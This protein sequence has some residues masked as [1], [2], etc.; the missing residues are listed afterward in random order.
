MRSQTPR[1]DSSA[2]PVPSQANG[3]GLQPV[4]KVRESPDGAPQSATDEAARRVQSSSSSE[5]SAAREAPRLRAPL[6]RARVQRPAR[7]SGAARHRHVVRRRAAAW[8]ASATA[9]GPSTPA[10]RG[11]AVTYLFRF[12]K[13]S[14][15]R[16]YSLAC[17]ALR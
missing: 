1:S 13:T 11:G 9:L 3:G 12:G 2:V 5:R 14:S 7:H 17:V 15:I 10:G 16:P 8:R 4:A 6:P